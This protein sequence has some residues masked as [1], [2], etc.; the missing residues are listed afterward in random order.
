M[1]KRKKGSKQ[2]I[3]HEAGEKGFWNRKQALSDFPKVGKSPNLFPE[4]ELE[5]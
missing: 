1:K 5:D 2:E 3:D 4:F